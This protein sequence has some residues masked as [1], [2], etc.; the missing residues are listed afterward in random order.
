[1]KNTADLHEGDRVNYASHM[2]A[3]PVNGM[4]KR[5][6]DFTDKV[7]VV[8]H[9]GGDWDNYK[10]YTAALTPISNLEQGWV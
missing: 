6:S 3:V 7:F 1:M 5:H 9:C 10:D 8:F 2:D 4:V